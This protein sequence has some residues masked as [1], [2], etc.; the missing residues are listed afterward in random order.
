MDIQGGVARM[1]ISLTQYGKPLEC[2][3]CH[4]QW[5]SKER[6]AMIT[7]GLSDDAIALLGDVKWSDIERT[8][9]DKQTNE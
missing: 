9:A 1:A 5:T 6:E 8:K 7:G 4:R 3:D 2:S